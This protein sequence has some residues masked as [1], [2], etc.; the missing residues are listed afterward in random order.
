MPRIYKKQCRFDFLLIDYDLI[1]EIDGVQ[2]T[3]EVSNK[4][5][6]SSLLHRQ[7][8]DKWKE[9][10]A[11]RDGKRVVRLDQPAIW[12]DTYDWKKDIKSQ[13]GL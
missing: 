12:A 2:H 9:F 4:W 5:I 13:L 8:V 1:L 10:V 11:R 6:R 3:E 7:I